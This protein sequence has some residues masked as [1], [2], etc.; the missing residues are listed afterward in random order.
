MI[1]M[2]DIAKKAG[3]SQATV[4]RVINGSA[5]VKAEIR[6]TVMELIEKFDYH[7]NIMA[8]SL[9]GNK[10]LLIGVIITDIANPFFSDIIKSIESE[11]TKYGYTIILCN[12][13]YEFDKEKKYINILKSYKVDGILIVPCNQEMSLTK[14]KN[15][16][17]PSLVI[18]QDLKGW[19][20]VSIS[21]YLAGKDVAKHLINMGYS[22]FAFVGPETDEKCRGF[23][24]EIEMSGFDVKKSFIIIEEGNISKLE[25]YIL[26]SF[27]NEYIGVFA[28]N[29][30]E[31]LIVLHILKKIKVDVPEKVALI[32]FDNTFISREVTPTISSVAQPI[33]EIG[34]QSIKILIDK[35]DPKKETKE[36]HIIL[37]TKIIVRE[38]TLK[39]IKN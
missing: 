29:D 5:P 36:E 7:P 6:A 33:E 26:N 4:S 32:G 21:H 23:K 12:T 15:I 28:Y 38:S 25:K 19:S 24:D 31:A 9:V 30:I 16:D 3:V 22:K 13:N 2:V 11:A 20:C 39:S 1:T 35:I 10:S 18:T 27:E 8:Q 14:L 37:N 34:K 17:I